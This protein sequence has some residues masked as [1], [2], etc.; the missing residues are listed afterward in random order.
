MPSTVTVKGALP[1]STAVV[2]ANPLPRTVAINVVPCWPMKGW[3]E[4]ARGSVRGCAPAHRVAN[5]HNHCQPHR[6]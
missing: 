2:P 5:Y 4:I 3:I 1:M 6:H